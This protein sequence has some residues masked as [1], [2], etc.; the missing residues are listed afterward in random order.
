MSSTHGSKACRHAKVRSRHIECKLVF[1]VYFTS[2]C[3]STPVVTAT[4]RA[5]VCP[6]CAII[7]KSGKP[8]CCAPGGAWF[9]NCGTSDSSNTDHTWAEGLQACKDV[10]SLFSGKEEAQFI[11]VNQ[12]RTIQQLNDVEKQIIDSILDTEYD[13]PTGNSKDND[14]LLQIFLLT[15]FCS[16]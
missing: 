4:R 9:E 11:F 15:I 8:S 16:F 14:Q 1:F 13:V 12:T 2:V 7:K 6:K 5:P 10:A 3:I